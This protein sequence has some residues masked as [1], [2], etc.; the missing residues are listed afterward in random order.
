MLPRA[1]HAPS[2]KRCRFYLFIFSL[3]PS[4]ASGGHLRA[5]A[6][7]AN[8]RFSISFLHSFLPLTPSQVPG[9]LEQMFHLGLTGGFKPG[10]Q[11][12]DLWLPIS[13][14]KKPRGAFLRQ[15]SLSAA[16]GCLLRPAG[17]P[18]ALR[19]RARAC[20]GVFVFLEPSAEPRAS[21]LSSGH[22]YF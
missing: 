4:Y 1:C 9:R 11:R 5:K 20:T 7:G 21:P 8:L 15:S 18:G 14:P 16:S 17:V 12:S 10:L 13:F 2:L 22:L 3:T 6:Q 19:G